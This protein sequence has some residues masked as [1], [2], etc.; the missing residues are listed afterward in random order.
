MKI[1]IG[2]L[3]SNG[4]GNFKVKGFRATSVLVEYQD[5]SSSLISNDYIE[6]FLTVIAE[7][8][9]MRDEQEASFYK[10]VGYLSVNGFIG[11]DVDEKASSKEFEEKYRNFTGQSLLKGQ[12]GFW[13][14]N[15]KEEGKR[16]GFEIIF[17]NTYGIDFENFGYHVGVT[18]TEERKINSNDL[19]WRLLE[20]GF[21]LGRKQNLGIIEKNIPPKYIQDFKAGFTK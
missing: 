16:M 13:L 18:N 20:L 2:S 14:V 1:G 7:D 17:P 12:L 5:G 10:A 8:N 9:P 19:G 3:G 15:G 21:V 11:A 4:K 6:K